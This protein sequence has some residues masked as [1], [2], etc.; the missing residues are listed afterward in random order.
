MH[1]PR[2]SPIQSTISLFRTERIGGGGILKFSKQIKKFARANF[3][4]FV[5][6]SGWGKNFIFVF[7]FFLEE[8]LEHA[9]A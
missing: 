7:S 3:G 5:S 4:K 9:G 1:A 8:V 2:H 6:D